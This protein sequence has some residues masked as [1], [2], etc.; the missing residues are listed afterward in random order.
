MFRPLP[1]DLALARILPSGSLFAVGGRVRDEL[2]ADID[3]ADIASKDLD[4]VVTGV[5]AQD[6]RE[7]LDS[8]GR[9][10]LVG[11]LFSVFKVTR[12]GMT[13]DVALPRRERSTGTGH[14]AFEV[15]GG[16]D[17]PLEEDLARRDFRMNML[18]RALPAG[19]IIDPYGGAADIR[20]HRVDVLT[21]RAFS[22]DPL[23]MLRGAQFA[24]RFGYAL[25]DAARAAMEQSAPLAATI[26]AERVADEVQKLLTLAPKPS[27]GFEI[28]RETGVLGYL[29]PELVKGVGVEQNEWHAYDV[30]THGMA[31]LDAMPQGDV[32]ARLAALLHD[33]GKPRTK[34]GPHF[35]RHEQVGADLAREML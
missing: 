1:M 4:Y 16:P 33:V 26:S 5:A 34:D 29:W 2:R 12:D 22:E 17:I 21:P 23:R 18:A 15:Q 30:W 24:A 8:I 11:A 27:L 20:A 32:T 6:L 19:E 25:S 10:D 28:L 7:R 3:G 35:Y 9:V 13:V 31:T 14:R